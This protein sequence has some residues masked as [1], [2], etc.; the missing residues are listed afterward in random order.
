MKSFLLTILFSLNLYSQFLTKD[1]KEIMDK[2]Y[3]GIE[4]IYKIKPDKAKEKFEE[5]IK[6]YPDHPF[7]HFGLAMSKWAE[8]E[9]LEE[10]S[11][12]KLNE[13][14]HDLSEKALEVGKS[15][16]KKNPN[17]ANAYMCLGGTYGLLARLYVM[18]HS[19][20]KAYRS[21][22]KAVSNMKKA[23]EI[24][25]TLYDAYLGL[26]LWEYSA[27]TLPGVIKFLA[28]LIVSGDA[29][30]GIEY[31]KI[32]AE[33]GRFNAT[34]A[35]LLL[36]EIFTQTDS[37]YSNPKVAVEWSN[38]LV[39]RYPK[40][41][42]M[43]FVLIVSLYEAKM[44]DEAEKEMLSYLKRIDDKTESYYPKY[45]PRIFVALGTL[46][47]MKSDYDKAF[48]YF[49]KAKEYIKYEEHPTR[50]AVWGAVRM[51]NIYDLKGV[52]NKAVEVY[53]EALGYKD[54][55]GF[56]E[57]IEEYIKKPFN[58]TMYLSKQLPP[59]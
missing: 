38:E 23:L 37:K 24:D 13:E 15:W 4:Y 53:K 55:W 42:Q 45:Y 18:Q 14:Y 35:K 56:K 19:W 46:Y 34:A 36:I 10:E 41:A 51:G 57:Y 21:G 54:Q 3:E 8:L 26:G 5:L 48:E 17:D 7:G 25:P 9:Y 32:C 50:W 44:Y 6:K 58:F 52:R 33:K 22:K 1:N 30:K 16:V 43:Q 49:L 47:M 28:S 2:A 40:L 20:W 59:P 39:E 12:P 29:K 11:S 27:G 31:L